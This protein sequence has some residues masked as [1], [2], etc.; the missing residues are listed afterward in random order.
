MTG[1]VGERHAFEPDGLEMRSVIVHSPP[2]SGATHRQIQHAPSDRSDTPIIRCPPV[3]RPESKMSF[4]SCDAPIRCPPIGRGEAKSCSPARR[5]LYLFSGPSDKGD[6]ID[7]LAEEK[8][9]VIDMV[10]IENGEEH[11]MA[12]DFYF[13]NLLAWIRKG[14][15]D[16]AFMSPP[17]LDV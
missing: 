1:Q 4:P 5:F 12:E 8:G 7:A 11:D 13:G 3:G 15:Y 2:Y 14:I 10:D 17:M 9:V 6:G 16:G